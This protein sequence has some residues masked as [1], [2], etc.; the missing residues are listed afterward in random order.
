MSQPQPPVMQ[1]LSPVAFKRRAHVLTVTEGCEIEL[2]PADGSAALMIDP[3][4]IGQRAGRATLYQVEEGARRAIG[5]TEI[6]AP[7]QP[8][9]RGAADVGQ[10]WDALSTTL[11]ATLAGAL[12]R[13]QQ[14][15]TEL[16][17]AHRTIAELRG[18]LAEQGRPD[19]FSAE[20]IQ[21]AAPLVERLVDAWQGRRIDEALADFIASIEDEEQREAALAAFVRWDAAG[22]RKAAAP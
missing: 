14:V 22:R 6:P 2:A 17:A 12:A 15:R 10:R 1:T 7:E 9:A 11:S 16:D 3:A 13:E 18:K 4:E 21:A 19:T 20:T 8:S 5:W